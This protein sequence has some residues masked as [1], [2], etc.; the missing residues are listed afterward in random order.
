MDF[1]YQYFIVVRISVSSAAVSFHNSQFRKKN[2]DTKF[3]IFFIIERRT[4]HLETCTWLQEKCSCKQN[5]MW[6]SCEHI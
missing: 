4:D 5:Q 1:K 2:K 3:Q 6:S